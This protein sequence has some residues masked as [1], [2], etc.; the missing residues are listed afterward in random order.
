M[1]ALERPRNMHERLVDELRGAIVSGELAPGELY[2][3]VDL[4]KTLEVSR[5]PVR[6]ALLTLASQGMVRFERNRGVRI[7]ETTV[8]DLGEVFQIRLLLEVPATHKTTQGMTPELLDKLR[9]ALQGM[10]DAIHDDD[11]DRMWENDRNFHRLILAGTG[12]QRIA[13][14]IDS[15]RVIVLTKGTTTARQ[16]R[17]PKDIVAEHSAI[18]ERIEEGDARAAAWAMHKHILHTAEL[19]IAQ[20]AKARSAIHDIDLD[21]G[22]YW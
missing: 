16:S 9:K 5:T 7:L 11:L 8:H 21:W 19:L 1:K 15:L 3:V 22:K 4:A 2:S 13:D 6:E 14:Y 20:E 18:F 17:E 12:N 10:H